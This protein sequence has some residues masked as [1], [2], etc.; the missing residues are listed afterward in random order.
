MS[1][2]TVI[3]SLQEKIDD[4]NQQ[5]WEARVNDSPKAFQLSQE[6]VN[7][8]RSI[9]Y[10]KGLAEGLRSL[11]FGY[12]RLFK[13]DEAA[14]LL[15]E[16]LSL[17]KSLNDVK[18]QAIVYEY[19]GIIERNWG[20][21]GTS[22]EL[23]LKGYGLIRQV[24]S[25]EVEVTCCY[26]IGVTYKHLG[27]HENALDYL[28]R[29]L[30]IA[31]KSNNA[32]MEAYAINIIGSI[33]FD[34]GDY[35]DALDCYQRGLVIR[36]ESH[37]KWGE[38]GSLDNIGFTYL[39]LNDLDK[40]IDYCKQ[41]LKIT[42]STGDKKGE[43]NTLLHLAET[44]Q[45]AGDIRQASA[46]SNE[47][48][49]IRKARGD[50]RG[51]AEVL[52]FLADLYKNGDNTEDRQIFEWLTGALK[53]ADEIKAQDL[54]SKAYYNLHEYH[55]QKGNHKESL[56]QLEA[57]LQIEKE[58]HK[59]TINQKISNLEI[60]HKAEVISQRNKELIELNEKIER[61][62]ADLKI[63]ASLERVRAVAMGMKEPADMINVCRMISDQLQQLGFKEIRNV[64]TVIIY[65]QK[66]EYLNYQYFIPYDKESIETIDYRLH[67][68]V[69]EFTNQMLSSADAYY[70]KTFEGD[71]LKVWREYRTQTNQLPDPRLDTTS[72]SHYYFY[73]IGSG[74]LGVTTYAPLSEEQIT[75]FKRFRNVFELAYRRF[76]DIEKALAQ[77][78]EAQI[79]LAL[80]RV[81]A[82]TMAMHRSEELSEVVKLLYQ[83]CDKLKINNES[84]DIEIGLIDEETGIASIWAHFYL[85]DG[86]IS[87]FN[88]PF[89]HFEEVN[90]EF[91]KW[92]AT[93]V[94][95][96]NELF[97]TTEFSAEQWQRFANIAE[98]LPEL[99]EIFRPLI[100]AKITKWVTH[101]A[102]FSHGILTLQGTEAY[103]Q[104]TQEI[105][106]R[107]AKVF[108][109]TYTRFLDLKKAEAQTKEAKIE[110]ALERVRAKSMAM[111]HSD[112]LI[113]VINVV[114]EQL[115]GLGFHFHAANF[116]TDYSEKGYTMWLA[117]PG[118]TFP[119][120]IYVP[121]VGLKYFEAVNAAIEKGSDFATYTLNFEEKNTYFKNLF[122]N[123]LAKNTSE[124]GKRIVFESKGMAASVVLLDKIRL[125]LMNLDM[126]PYTDEENDILKR[127]GYVFEQSY[128]RFL[129]LKKAEAQTREAQIE[130]AVERLRAKALAMHRSEDLHGVVVALKKELMG[131]Q[132]PGVIAATIYLG[133][134]DGS[135]RILDLSGPGGGEDDG[136]ELKLD[137]FFRLEDTDP[138]LWVRRMWEGT[139]KYFVLEADEADF[140]RVV[141][142]LH[143][144]D[145]AEAEIA[146]NIIKEYA[147][148]KAWLPTVKL[149][150]GRLN[151]D[152][153]QPPTA[154][155]ES[156]LLKMG[157]G[158]D[159]AYKRFL[160]LQK[161]EAQTKEAQ[162]EVALERIR[163]RA[164]AMHSSNE[165][166]EVA[167]ILREQMGLL[168]QPDL[169][170]S[171]INLFEEDSDYIHSWHAFK[172]PGSSAGKTVNGTVSFR[173]DSSELTKEMI[174]HYH[175]GKKEFT[176][177]ATGE[178]LNEFIQV[179][180]T[181]EPEISNYIGKHPPGKVYYHFATFTGGALLT[182][183]YQ[184]TTEDI[185]TLQRRAASVFDMAYRRYRDLK[186]AEA[187]AREAQ[188]ET[189]LERV[190]SKTMAMH[191]SE[192]VTGVAVTLN[193]ELLKLGF[194]GGSTIIIINR[195]TGDT[196]Q[197]TGFSED[198]TI[199]S[200]N[201]PYFKHPCHDALLNAWKNGDKFLVYTVA[202]DEKR[203]LDEH[204]FTTGYKIFPENDKKW[205]REMESVTFSHAFMKYGAIHWGPGHLTEEQLRILQRFS[206]VFEQSYTRF[207]DLQ[208]AEAQAR[209]AQIEA[210]VEKVRSRSLAMHKSDEL[211]EVVHTV[212]ERLKELEVDFYTA[213]IVLFKED[214]KD[215]IWWLE[216]K[217]NQQYSRISIPYTPIAYFKD[218]F[219]KRESGGDMLSKFYPFDE[220]NKLFHHLFANTDFKDVPE[221][222]KQFLLG[223][224]FVTIS[225][226]L[227]RN[228]GIHISSYS[229]K[230]FSDQ[231]N[232]IIK[233]FANVFD[234]AYTRFLDLQKAEA[235]AREA[236]IETALERVRAKVMAMTSSKDLNETSLVFGEQLRK[237]G[238]D[239][240]FSYFWLIEEAR[241]E[242]TFWIT[243]PDNKTSFTSYT[244]AEAE[245][246]FND[247]LISWRA[248]V[249]IHDNYV[250]PQGVQLWL[251]TFQ[252]IADD[253]GGEAKK[254]MVPETFADGVYYYDAMMKYG[255]FGI[256]IN[257]PATDEEKKIQCRFAVEFERAY[258][259]FLDLR[260]AEAQAR[261]AQIE[262]ALERVRSRTMGMQR[263]GE[264]PEAASLLFQQIQSLGVNVFSTGY[265]IW[266]NDKKSVT[267]WMASQ[268]I[269]QPP[270]KLPLTEE[271]ALIDCYKAA[272]QGDTFFIQQ[273]S[274]EKL[275]SHLNYMS[276][277]PVIGEIMKKMRE[278]GISLPG[279]MINHHA[280]FSHGYLLFITYEPVP[281]AHDIFKRFAKV[282][283]QT[284]TRFLDLEKAEAQAREARIEVA[285]ERVRSKAMA[286]HK[287]DDLKMAVAT[288]FE[289]LDKLN[290]GILRCGIAIMDKEKPRADVWITV[291]SEQT[292]TI[293]VSG[294]ESLDYHPLLRGAY[295]GWVKQED[296]SYVLRGKDLLSY[297]RDVASMKYQLPVSTPFDKEK[298]DQQQY[299]FNAVFQDGS[300]FAFMETPFTD[301]AKTVMKRFANVFNL[302]YKRF[303][304]LQKAEAQAREA[305]I[306]LGLERVRARAMAMQKSDELKE[307]IG[308]VSTELSKL[309]LILDRCFIMTYDIKTLGATWWMANPETSSD[310]IGLY[311]K[312]H[313]HTPSL[314]FLKAWQDRVLKWQYIL[315]GS[316]K[317]NW[318]EFLFV[319][320][321]LARL[322]GFVID[323]MR[324]NEKVYLSASFNN[325][326]CLTLATLAPLSDEQFDI[327]L[328]FAK[329]FDLTYTRFNDLK[330]AEAQ[331]RAAKIEA[332]LERVRARALAMQEPEELKDVAHVLRT[333]M[334][335][336][337]VEELETC[338]IYI[339]D[340]S[341]EKAECWYALKDSN[342]DEKKLVND[343]FALN[344]NDT[345]VGREMLQFYQSPAKQISIVMQGE[346]RREWILY[347]EKHSAP[348]RGHY[349]EVIP[350]R[351]YHLYKF[352]H[353]AIG[354]AAAG[355][356]SE[357][358]WHMLG[359]AASVFTLAYSRFKDLTQ[360]R[361][362]LVKLKE[363]KKRAEDALTELQ[364]T[365][366]QLIQSEKMASLGEL[367]AG[368][369][370]EIQNP[371]NFVNNFSD[372]SNELLEEMKQELATGNTQQAI[373]IVNGVKEN[374]EKI[375]HHGKRADA[376]VK[377]MLQHSRSSSGQK[378]PTDIN[379][380]AEE[381]LRL[382]YH[383]L[384][385]KDKFFNAK[386]ETDL[387]PS[388][389]KI[390]VVPQE[391]GRVILNLINNAFYAVSEKKKNA[392]NGYEPIVTVSTKTVKPPLGGLGVVEIKVKDNG[393][394]IPQKML[395]KIFQP[396]FTTK[397]TG[398]GT[399]L[400]LSLSYDIITKG[401][402]GEIKVETKEGEGSEFTITLPM[403]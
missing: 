282:F 61:A 211:Q 50:K 201:V 310:P 31:K 208:K 343:H 245:E 345:W 375:L 63:E 126:I 154:E 111:H 48:L 226:A 276:T 369:A 103:S 155:V 145:K 47:S 137:K 45:Q 36:R 218:L 241:N 148:K 158:F 278:A 327:M 2:D 124:E 231:D 357:E 242:N 250:P 186:K 352:S 280:F 27:N 332:A 185:K 198:R 279:Y 20:N 227:A 362:D 370:H 196:E 32:L 18:G 174:D 334:G 169:E 97:F 79:Q 361:S 351:T 15:R 203:S 22:L 272:Q 341:A 299:Y 246:Y 183:S 380:L 244:I 80:E 382:A 287:S 285:L 135:I 353:G 221:T 19:L 210:A 251:D 107:F 260:Q 386:F 286:M 243:W 64:Q 225:V 294:D 121:Q 122:E 376:I 217:A 172:E 240:Q 273:L 248:G 312:Y 136:L 258:T 120:K 322:P 236:K 59:N 65:P 17:F 296:F 388:I 177:E 152:L 160:D 202:G 127:F 255:S 306:E 167:H 119:Y 283:E 98:G 153:L 335:L 363:E 159:L 213:I 288:V 85:S 12:V 161:A 223:A 356:I 301:E 21:L 340:E 206:K 164:M 235:Q 4:L 90:E 55:T 346:N 81:R 51:E 259:R 192:E 46:F 336:L 302:T 204:Y 23:L 305:Q 37:D 108:E 73:S 277:L 403:S 157:A 11:G 331:T 40:A 197:W 35:N 114:Q 307:L 71:E 105:L 5:A 264:L 359:R 224:E 383:G 74:A 24:G 209:E 175:S 318:D 180:I 355:E 339:N 142:F 298:I 92:K 397:P 7:L 109:Q 162:T 238:I 344:L 6:S 389:N 348:L 234:Q 372:V 230:S 28:Y 364:A 44:F 274:G 67:P 33:Y 78:R 9:N 303:L 326:G 256:C 193:E 181:S 91:K 10:S 379:V 190:R 68:D 42:Q 184:P 360:A 76:I 328:R 141:A 275:I 77:A 365:Q 281:E 191:K 57:H 116:V 173:K 151:I 156:I 83:E 100:E 113:T 401:H 140:K 171:V 216:S 95:K 314:A 249:K 284:Y 38:A 261:E 220:K 214:S 266:E 325:F 14:P 319:E 358:S 179:L 269:I 88:F 166:M 395:D 263:S 188:I 317:K 117:S 130:V 129:D 205:M 400:G 102:Y 378:E 239:W 384:R 311:V 350:D 349:G 289:E 82:R 385:A 396:F 257:K 133:Q 131:L 99:S 30:S 342:A 34:N 52:L 170:T 237:L 293:Q 54:L 29:A 106:K 315:E 371:L 26:Q 8:A 373:E 212:F 195:E 291:K 402:D 399:G 3:A 270:F 394:G 178:K 368:I 128:T 165:L 324:A 187:Q 233:R 247:C 320:T 56:I 253:A 387:D 381:Y 168:D 313:E 392:G 94:E 84:T 297:Y 112:D 194:E 150:K 347:C 290:I 25:L 53:I 16:S 58:L 86:T 338:S 41:S 367:T 254:I 390:S 309:D 118:E 232:Q 123:S 125:N 398:Q 295:D 139:Q 265:N 199:K 267:S 115:L 321:E 252:R 43:A 62:N 228:T 1:T 354:A 149:E 391:I 374:L 304:D 333:E 101:N 104:E 271:A 49:E 70:T 292:N 316:V 366:K 329:V 219:D 200:C 377:G 308:T 323:N 337:G 89:T 110:A 39:K 66:H 300:L 207:L 87:T 138:D 72:S 134:D 147:I 182:V 96:R 262:T 93:P 189:G 268:G 229:K 13:N 60:S 393:N 330:Q 176:L 163:A 222:Q 146:E 215:I 75:L 144:V 132:I 69:L 143:T